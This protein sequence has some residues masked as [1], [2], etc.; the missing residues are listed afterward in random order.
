MLSRGSLEA[1]PRGWSLLVSQLCSQG[2]RLCSGCSGLLLATPQTFLQL[3]L[4]IMALLL[5]L[6]AP[7]QHPDYVLTT[8]QGKQSKTAAK[9]IG[10]GFVQTSRDTAQAL[11]NKTVYL[12]NSI[13]FTCHVCRSFLQF[14]R[15]DPRLQH[16]STCYLSCSVKVPAQQ[17]VLSVNVSH[18]GRQVQQ[19]A[20]PPQAT[21]Q[22][23]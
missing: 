9:G 10:D 19:Q 2:V 23:L 16:S 11:P 13:P 17:H 18:T 12:A 4:V 5:K 7:L 8:S 1:R 20:C 3:S 15:I 6:V 14:G 22:A 21:Q